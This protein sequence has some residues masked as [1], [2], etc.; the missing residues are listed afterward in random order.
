[1]LRVSQ[2]RRPASTLALD[3]ERTSSRSRAPRRCSTSRDLRS[4]TGAALLARPA[5]HD[6]S[7]DVVSGARSAS[8]AREASTYSLLRSSTR[9]SSSHGLQGRCR[10]AVL[11]CR[12]PTRACSWREDLAGSRQRSVRGGA[13]D[14]PHAPNAHLPALRC[15]DTTSAGRSLVP[16]STSCPWTLPSGSRGGE[17]L[18]IGRSAFVLP[19][20]RMRWIESS[21]P[22]AGPA[23]FGDQS[24]AGC[25]VHDVACEYTAHAT[26]RPDGDHVV[27]DPT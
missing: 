15:E 2:P 26:A 8:C 10:R 27:N 7:G 20:T 19:P 16:E 9:S 21:D 1:M 12:A 3:G 18:G 4:R 23:A 11:T 6:R 17:K 13:R 22:G 25:C 5:G 24:D 14:A